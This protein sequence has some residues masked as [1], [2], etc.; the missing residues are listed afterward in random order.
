MGIIEEGKSPFSARMKMLLEENDV[1]Q[2]QLAE[3]LKLAAST[4]SGYIQG[5]NEPDFKTL[6][7]LADYFHVT[8][9]YLLGHPVGEVRSEKEAELLWVFRTLPEEQQD[10]F[11]EQGKAVSRYKNRANAKLSKT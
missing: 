9:D 5:T 11:I 8:T 10:I 3:Y 4:V 2:K 1:K 6:I 7:K